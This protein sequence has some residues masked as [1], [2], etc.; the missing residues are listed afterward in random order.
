M[1][2]YNIE[3]EFEDVIANQDR[4]KHD[5]AIM[6]AVIYRQSQLKGSD[7]PISDNHIRITNICRLYNCITWIS[8]IMD[9]SDYVKDN[10]YRTHENENRDRTYPYVGTCSKYVKDVYRHTICT[11]IM[12]SMK[13]NTELLTI[14]EPCDD[15][16][17][18]RSN[19]IDYSLM[20]SIETLH[21]TL[22]NII[23]EVETNT[24]IENRIVESLINGEQLQAWS[25]GSL[26]GT[27]MGH[28][29][30]L[31]T[32]N[33]H[34]DNCIRGYARSLDGTLRSSLRPEHCG[35]LAIITLIWIL[36][37]KTMNVREL[38]SSIK[39]FIDNSTVIRRLKGECFFNIDSTDSDVWE[40]TIKM[41]KLCRTKFYFEHVKSHQDQIIGPISWE[42]LHNV[43][44]DNLAKQGTHLEY[45][46]SNQT[47]IR[48][49]CDIIVNG[50]KL[51]A[52]S[53][54]E[55]Y[56]HMAGSELQKYMQNKYGWND[57]VFFGI[58]WEGFVEYF[59]GINITKIANIIKPV[60]IVP[61]E[62]VLSP[63]II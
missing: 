30:I 51:T 13:V 22:C 27:R 60:N 47:I 25:D 57:G 6:D 3:I 46:E 43:T 62:E 11:S 15:S 42:Q 63:S 12:N 37:A 50:N 8:E 58:D 48:S 52:N 32:G 21:P 53:S 4:A 34:D 40:I 31:R 55:L 1:W 29:Y 26:V 36:E 59:R 17:L 5:M 2:E 10:L 7:T 56:D 44:V 9:G 19:R 23:G 28:G 38:N 33:I 39:I 61:I 45:P 24:E 41:I 35:A 49:R 16:I 14:Q 20:E 18:E 54:R